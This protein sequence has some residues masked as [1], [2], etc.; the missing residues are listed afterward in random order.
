[1]SI[2]IIDPLIILT[3]LLQKTIEWESVRSSTGSLV[4]LIPRK[5]NIVFFSSLNICEKQCQPLNPAKLDQLVCLYNITA[6]KQDLIHM[7]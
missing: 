5:H 2:I 7:I 3:V 6:L 1:M 4:K